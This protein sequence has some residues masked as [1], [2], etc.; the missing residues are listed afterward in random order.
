MYGFNIAYNVFQSGRVTLLMGESDPNVINLSS[1]DWTP[2]DVD[3]YL[4][5]VETL[6]LTG[7]TIIF[8]DIP[9]SYLSAT[10]YAT[11]NSNNTLTIS[12][13]V[14][15][16]TDEILAWL[17]DASVSDT[18]LD[19]RDYD[20]ETS[21]ADTDIQTI[22]DNDNALLLPDTGGSS[23]PS[24]L[25]HQ[26]DLNETSGAAIDSVGSANGTVSGGVTRAGEYYRFD[27]VDG[28]VSTDFVVPD[29]VV[30]SMAIRPQSLAQ[31]RIW[32]FN[33]GSTSLLIYSNRYNLYGGGFDLY[34]AEAPA[35]L[36]TWAH[37]ICHVS[38]GN[39]ARL[40]FNGAL[41]AEDTA[42]STTTLGLFNFGGTGTEYSQV[43]IDNLKIFD[44]S[45]FDA[46]AAALVYSLDAK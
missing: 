24:G 46:T 4:M 20:A 23:Y 18:I 40:Y 6:A 15:A 8:P 12:A 26:Y 35:A 28:M 9:R 31:K 16:N 39:F 10:E 13:T 19:M 5:S 11:V 34:P 43:D 25:V 38:K 36:D 27:G 3:D 30:I 7:K 17:A 1:R 14:L 33:T 45:S 32:Q 41:V 2:L 37:V 42:I 44:G 22:Y 29:N 21:A